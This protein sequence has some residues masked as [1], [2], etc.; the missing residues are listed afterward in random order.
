MSCHDALSDIGTAVNKNI[1]KTGQIYFFFPSFPVL[2]IIFWETVWG[3]P[4]LPSCYIFSFPIVTTISAD[5]L[6]WTEKDGFGQIQ[7]GLLDAK[8]NVLHQKMLT[9][10]IVAQFMAS[11]PALS[12]S[13]SAATSRSIGR[14]QFLSKSDR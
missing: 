14:G 8:D 10:F 4:L 11:I 6:L 9:S 12:N 5:S 7:D 2:K 1:F 13:T 3:I